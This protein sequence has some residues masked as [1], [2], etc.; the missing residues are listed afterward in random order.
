MT[1]KVNE[2]DKPEKQEEEVKNIETSSHQNNLIVLAI[3]G[4]LLSWFLFR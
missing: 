3:G 1:S 2:K 4:A